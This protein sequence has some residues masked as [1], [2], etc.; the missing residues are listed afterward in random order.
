[1]IHPETIK[2]DFP[3]FAHH[4]DLIYLDSAA[5]ALKPQVVIDAEKEYLEQYSTNIARG[6]YPLAETATEK[7]DMT[8][9]KI[10]HF[11]GAGSADEIIFTS[12]TTD[13]IN[14]V[15]LLLE[16]HVSE[17]DNIITTEMEHHSNFLPW[18]E[19]AERTKADFRVISLT[20]TGEID[21]ERLKQSIDEKTKIVAFSAVSNVLGTINPVQEITALIKNINRDIMV[22]IDGAQAIAHNTINVTEWDIDFLAFSGHKMFGP[23]GIG[24]LYG[25]KSILNTLAPIIFGGGMVL[26]SCAEKTLYKEAPYRFEAGTPHI[27]GIIALGMAIHYIQS[28]G[29]ENIRKHEQSLTTYALE[30]LEKAFGDAITLLGPKNIAIRGGI[31]SFV[32]AGVHPH[33]IA[34]VLGEH[35]I[36][37]RAGEHCTTPLHRS[38]GLNATTR[39]S[40]SIYNT[41][42]D[43]DRLV[44]VLKEVQTMFR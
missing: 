43:I 35:N 9:E 8:R 42:R 29:L 19:L 1:M 18:K 6:V 30:R 41:E 5:T 36:C 15:A 25:R 21:I 13:G 32:M 12:G 20:Q 4:P 34:A 27:G 31:I 14:L 2:K 22:V 33:D 10:A 7:C 16:T 28:L 23:T 3:I 37:V 44:D 11:I 24:V 17:G 26:D 38:L 39:I 40:L